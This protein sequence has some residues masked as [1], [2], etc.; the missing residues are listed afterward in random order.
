MTKRFTTSIKAMTKSPWT[1]TLIGVGAAL[2]LAIGI[3]YGVT[4][5]GLLLGLVYGLW[6]GAGIDAVRRQLHHTSFA[7]IILQ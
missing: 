7:E 6:V 4:L 2:G 5:A 1:I 3:N